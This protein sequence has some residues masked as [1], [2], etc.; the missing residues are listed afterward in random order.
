M[1]PFDVADLLKLFEVKSTVEKPK[2]IYHYFL[3]KGLPKE[4]FSNE[5]VNQMKSCLRESVNWV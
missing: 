5:T 4:L 3:K 1:A 2:P